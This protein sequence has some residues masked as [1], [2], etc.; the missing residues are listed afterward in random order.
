MNRIRGHNRRRIKDFL[1]N[2]WDIVICF[3]L[4]IRPAFKVVA[5]LG[6]CVG[7]AF[8]LR[9][10]VMGSPYFNVRM[11]RVDTGQHV[12]RADVLRLT[13]LNVPQNIFSFDREAAERALVSHQWVATA[14]IKVILPNQ[15][16]VRIEEKVVAGVLASGNLSL[17]DNDGRVFVSASPADILNVPIVTGVPVAEL[18]QEDGARAR[19]RVAL[20]LARLYQRTSMSDSCPLSSVH[21]GDG[22]RFELMIGKTRVILGRDDFQAKLKQLATIFETLSERQADAK[23][24]AFGEDSKRVIVRETA[25]ATSL[26][27]TYSL[28]VPGA[29]TAC[30]IN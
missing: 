16:S 28:H 29:L 14:R 18:E 27:N 11:V 2:I 13:G 12:S 30:P 22:G 4:W 19:V 7:L 1:V 17:L 21:L 6:V 3:G 23:Y 26:D 20:S 9:A 10:A 25:Q 15:V 5:I 24:I 8:A